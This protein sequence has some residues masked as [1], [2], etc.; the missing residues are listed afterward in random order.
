[1]TKYYAKLTLYLAGCPKDD[2]SFTEAT[3]PIKTS[4]WE[5]GTDEH[6]MKIVKKYFENGVSP[7]V[8]FHGKLSETSRIYCR[9]PKSTKGAFMIDDEFARS[10]EEAKIVIDYSEKNIPGAEGIIELCGCNKEFLTFW[11]RIRFDGW[12][13]LQRDTLLE[14]LKNSGHVA[15]YAKRVVENDKNFF[16]EKHLKEI[17]T[18]W[19]EHLWNEALEFFSED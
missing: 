17:E 13:E 16:S 3:F 9:A 7:I 5:R 2:F 1:M 12:Q 8:E 18:S 6:A 19:N 15:P 11:R 14:N 10:E 4:F